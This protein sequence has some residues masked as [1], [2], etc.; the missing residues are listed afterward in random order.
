[1]QAPHKNLFKNINLTNKNMNEIKNFAKAFIKAQ[2]EM[3]DAK[4]DSTNP[5]FKNKYADL[6]SVREACV[7]A[8]NANGIAVLQPIVQVEG[9]NFVKTLLL[10]ESGESMECLTEII[11]AKQ[12]DA[13]AQGSG[14]TYARRYGLQSLVN[15]GAEDDD[16]NKA[17]EQS[18]NKKEF[19]KEPQGQMKNLSNIA[20]EELKASAEEQRLNKLKEALSKMQSAQEIQDYL[21]KKYQGKTR[22]EILQSMSEA[23]AEKA[24][25][26]IADANNDLWMDQED[27]KD[28]IVVEGE[29]NE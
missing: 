3:G 25:A 10:H 9:K 17:N 27:D 1:L 21:A 19:F 29:T 13:Q 22:L 5:F 16:G 18:K 20:S 26:F 6:N 24:M 23:N 28:E 2:S 4:K 12:N 15:V 8:L 7:P 14:I 11:Y